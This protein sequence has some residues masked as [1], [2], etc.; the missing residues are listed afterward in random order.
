LFWNIGLSSVRV[1]GGQ[2]G[3]CLEEA[4]E[5]DEEGVVG[6]VAA[7]ADSVRH[8]DGECFEGEMRIR[9]RKLYLEPKP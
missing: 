1:H 7:K 3:C 9:P 8:G 2:N 4:C 6:D 5:V